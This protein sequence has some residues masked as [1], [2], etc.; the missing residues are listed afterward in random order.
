MNQ[1]YT[2]RIFADHYQFYIFDAREDFFEDMP[3]W[4]EENAR[5]GYITNGQTIYLG[6]RAHF[7][8]HWLDV[9]VSDHA[10]SFD[11]CE[12]ALAINIK[13]ASGE[14]GIATPIDSVANIPIKEGS[15]YIAYILGFNIGVDSEDELTDEELEKRTD[16]ERYTIVFVPGNTPKEGVV[17]G[18]QYLT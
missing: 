18:E 3:D 10:P 15:Y 5:K 12:R 8:D 1:I 14:L 6:T 4:D 11:N 7:H 2:G 13:I 16:F 9:Y 17:K